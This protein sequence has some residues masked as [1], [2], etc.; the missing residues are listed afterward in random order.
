MNWLKTYFSLILLISSVLA[1]GCDSEPVVTLDARV[2][3][4]DAGRRRDI[5]CEEVCT[6]R[7]NE[8]FPG[9]GV[10]AA[11]ASICPTL[12]ATEVE[13]ASTAACSVIDNAL[14]TGGTFCEVAPDPACT[15]GDPPR[16][17]GSSAIE[18]VSSPNGPVMT[19]TR[20]PEGCTEGRCNES[21]DL[22][23]AIEIN[24]T[25]RRVEPVVA[26]GF[27]QLTLR[28]EPSFSPDP[29]E[30]PSRRIADVSIE[31]DSPS[32]EC[33]T[34]LDTTLSLGRSEIAL[35]LFG[36]EALCGEF[37]DT[38]LERGVEFTARNAMYSDGS[39][40]TLSVDL[41]PGT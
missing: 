5:S 1:T 21:P 33:T 29:R 37:A 31:I 2:G 34:E 3:G 8:C 7:A 27:V 39:S 12:S 41:R 6:A 17:E 28:A 25:F 9:Q 11:C 35:T 19:T 20:C 15:L 13:C 23:S 40:A 10:E 32:S 18:C 14:E 24:G 22:P 36:P 4:S 16:C 26:A 38:V 30:L